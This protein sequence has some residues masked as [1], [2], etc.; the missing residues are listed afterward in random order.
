L[1]FRVMLISGV[2]ALAGATATGAAA[3]AAPATAAPAMTL[4]EALKALPAY[5]FGKSREALTVITN[6]LCASYGKD[7]ARSKLV[8][9]LVAVLS[10][11]ATVEAKRFVCRE[12]ALVGTA[13]EVPALAALLADKDLFDPARSALETIPDPAADAALRA[14]LA[15]AAPA[16]AVG[17]VNSLGNRSQPGNAATLVNMTQGTAP[18][19]A[20]AATEALARHLRG[21]ATRP[22]RDAESRLALYEETWAAIRRPEE[23]RILLEGLVSLGTPMALEMAT[24]C[25]DDETVRAEALTAV[26]A[27]ATDLGKDALDSV[28][29][30]MEKVLTVAKDPKV[31]NEAKKIL[32]NLSDKVNDVPLPVPAP[33]PGP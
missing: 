5:E 25:L 32:A 29:A 1:A 21:A 15:K 16:Q 22:G 6:A 4:D 8:A 31:L 27:M 17:L 24:R 18:A 7:E 13:R 12:L 9:S 11:K 26:M 3:L 19:V 20:A 10:S 23:K 28:Q 2:L 14:A 33:P 30:A